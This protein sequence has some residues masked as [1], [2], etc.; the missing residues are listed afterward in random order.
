[1]RAADSRFLGGGKKGRKKKNFFLK[2]KQKTFAN[3]VGRAAR[4]F[5]VAA[6]IRSA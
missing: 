3:F 5:G 4:K 1:M 6:H 2:K